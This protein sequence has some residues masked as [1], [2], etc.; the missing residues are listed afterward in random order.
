MNFVFEK[1]RSTG[2]CG[3]TT[4][5]PDYAA[6]WI[7]TYKEKGKSNGTIRLRFA[8]SLQ[9]IAYARWIKGDRLSVGGDTDNMLLAFKRDPEGYKIT[10]KHFSDTSNDRTSIQVTVSE[11][12]AV[13]VLS[14]LCCGKWIRLKENGVLLV[15]ERLDS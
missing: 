11:N 8:F 13:N 14:Q 6:V 4:H 9:T 5:D 10:G 1:K 15:T 2:N 12:S 3:T 7:S